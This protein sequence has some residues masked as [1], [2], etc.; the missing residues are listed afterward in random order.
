MRT[1]NGLQ[2]H[3][4]SYAWAIVFFSVIIK[5]M[6]YPLTQKQY[7]SMK[8]MQALQPEIKRLQARYKDDPKKFNEAQAE[9]FMKAGVNPLGGCLPFSY[10]CLSSMASIRPS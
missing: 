1:L 4:G 7:S 2:E 6:L 5:V 10:R 3:T 9:L 8:A